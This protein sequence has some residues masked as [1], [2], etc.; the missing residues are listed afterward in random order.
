MQINETGRP[1]TPDRWEEESKS[2]NAVILK[3][4]DP[5]IERDRIEHLD[6]DFIPHEEWEKVKQTWIFSS[7]SNL[8]IPISKL[9]LL[10]AVDHQV[11]EAN[12]PVFQ[13]ENIGCCSM[14]RL[15]SFGDPLDTLHPEVKE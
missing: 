5:N 6:I 4:I 3:T 15:K 12:Q 9:G 8:D 10:N 11:L 14:Q 7:G 2:R 1:R 13:S